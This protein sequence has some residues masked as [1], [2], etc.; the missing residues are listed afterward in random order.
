P[1]GVTS[2]GDRAFRECTSLTS[3]TIPDSVTSIGEVAFQFCTSLTSI[4]IPNSVTSIGEGAFWRCISLTSITIPDGFTSIGSYTFRECYSL[5]SITIPDSVTSIGRLAF[6]GCSSLTS[7]TIPDGVPSIADWAFAGCSSLTSITIP[8]SVTSIGERAFR[9]CT[10]LT[11]ITFQGAAPTVG[12]NAFLDV[13]NGA[14]ALVTLENHASFGNLGVEWNGLTVSMSA[15]YLNELLTRLNSHSAAVATARTAGQSDVTSDP[16]SYSLVTQ[17]SYNAVVAERDARPTAEQL[18]A[19]EAERDARPTQVS[20]DSAVAASRVAGQD[21]VTTNPSNYN[22]TTGE[23]T[24]TLDLKAGWNL[25]SFYVEADDMTPATVF[26]PIQNKLL[27]VKNLTESYDPTLTADFA[28]LNTLSSLNMKDGYWINVSEDV[29]LDVEGQVGTVVEISELNFAAVKTQSDHSPEEK[30]GPT[31]GEATVYPNLG[32]TV[33]AKVSIQGKPVAKGGVVA[34]FVG[35]ELRGI[36]DVILN[37]GISYVTLNVNLNGAESVS[38]RVWNPNENNE[39]LVSGTMLLELGSM[40]G[41]PELMELDAVTVV[42]KPLQVFKLTSEPFGFSFNTTVD[43]S[44]TVEA[45]GD[46]RSWKAVELFQGSGGE[47]RFTAE[48]TSSG[49]SQFFRV[50]VK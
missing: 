19:V 5:T 36:Q 21:D 28:F 44:Y 10:N 11:S 43:R 27:L 34:A 1:D 39:Y 13:A 17:T 49:K 32:A 40:Y 3:I 29:S 26:A 46:L 2:I 45:T 41:K 42:S 35:N 8:D 30:A 15:A 7:I 24:Q 6:K 16:T 18:A 25:V 47:I 20:Y 23:V 22:L 48:P 14:V 38:Y 37:D 4:T 9:D 50:F 12:T 31:W 33:L